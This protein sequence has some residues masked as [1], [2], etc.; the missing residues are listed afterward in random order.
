MTLVT[1]N[2]RKGMQFGLMFF[3][4]SEDALLGNKYRL[5]IESAK[6]A[7]QHSFSSVWLPE[8][9]FTKFGCLY[10]NPSV[11]H[12]ALARETEHIRL[13]AGSVVLPI[14]NPIRIAEEWAVVDNL[15]QGRIGISFASGW[16]PNDFA[17]FPEKYTN[18]HEEMYSGIKMVQKLWQGES[19][20]VKNGKGKQ[21]EVRVYPTP[22]Q[23]QLPVWITAASNPKTFI[24][25][26]EIGANLLTHMF[27]QGIEELAEKIALYRQARAKYG[28]EPEAGQVTVTLHTF[29]GDDID[30]VREQVRVPYC[31][32][33]KSNISLLKGLAQ[34]RD[35]NVDIS[36]LPPEELDDLVNFVF[37]KFSSS[38]ALFGTPETC[39]DLLSQLD[40][41]GVNEV[42][43]L[44]DFGLDADL[45]LK[46]LP[47]LKQLKE[48]YNGQGS[49]ANFLMQVKDD[50]LIAPKLNLS[51]VNTPSR[52]FLSYS[53]IYPQVQQEDLI[54]DIQARC[55]EEIPGYEFYKGLR[56]HGIY[57]DASF[58]GIQCLWRRNGEALGMVQFLEVLE[59]EVDA[60]KIH[61]AFLDACFQ[62][63]FATLPT[64]TVSINGEVLYIPVG[65]RS[66]EICGQLGEQV[67]SHAVLRSQPNETADIFEGDVCIFNQAGKLVLKV[68]GLRLQPTAIVAQ[69]TRQENF[70]DW[71]YELEWKPKISL[72]QEMRHLPPDYMLTPLQLTHRLQPDVE[73]LISQ[74]GFKIYEE[75]LPELNTLS[76][77]Y[78]VRAFQ[79]LGWDF[80]LHKCF[81]VTSLAE[82]L[83]IVD[84]YRR[85]LV[86]L[87]EMLQEEEVL[88]QLD[89]EWEICRVPAVADPQEYCKRLLTLYP[90]CEAELTLL[91]RCGQHL[92]EVLVGKCDPLQLLFPAGSS[93]S[94]EKLYQDSPA[95]QVVNKLVQ[96]AV[97]IAMERLPEER[98]VR[99]LEIGAGTGGTTSYVLSQ[100]PANQTEYLFTDL[101]NLF[102]SKAKQKFSEYPFV[103]YQILDIEQDPQA[104][105]FGLHQ[106]DVILAANVLHATSNLRQTL[107]HIRQILAS[108]GLLVLLEGT[109]RQRW[110]D[111]IFG[112]TEGWWKFADQDLRPSYPLLTHLQWLN[113][114][115]Q[116]GFM[117]VETIP[118][119]QDS[120]GT[121]SQQTLILARN[122]YVEQETEP[123]EAIFHVPDRQGSWLVFA[124]GGGVGQKFAEQLRSC[125]EACT[126]VFPGKS[127]VQLGE[128][129]FSINPAQPEDF[130]RLVNEGIKTGG[131][132]YRGVVHLWSLEAADPEAMTV[133]DLE[134]SFV[135]GC[136]S[137]LHL[138]QALVSDRFS[139]PPSLWLVTQGSQSVGSDPVSPA[140]A[141][142]PLWGLGRV[143]SVEHPQLWGGLVDLDSKASVD[144]S[145]LE[146]SGIVWNQDGEDQVAF[147]QKQCYVARL[148]HKR[149]STEKTLP[150][151]WRF[152]SSY[153]ITGGLG[154]LGL[155]V[156]HWMVEQGARRLILLGRTKL[157]P[158]ANWSAVQEDSPLYNQIKAVRDLESLGATVYLASA[159]VANEAQMNSVLK[160]LQEQGCPS[161][162]GVVH[163][164]GVPQ[165]LRPLQQLEVTTMNAVLRPKVVGSWLL[166]RLLKH[167][168]LDFFV[169]FSSWSS[170]LGV[171]GQNLGSYSAANT[172]LD[173]MAH[174]R[175]A[176]GHTSLSINWGDW[177]E[178]GMRARYI[179]KG[180]RLLPENWTF[181]PKQGINALEHLLW[182]SSVQVGV[183]PVRWSDFFQRFPLMNELPLLRDIALEVPS[184]LKAEERLTQRL[185]FLQTLEEVPLSK[186]RELLLSY[187]QDQAVKVLG[188]DPSHPP[189]PEQSLKELGLDSLMAVEMK[190]KFE[191]ELGVTI[192]IAKFFEASSIAQLVDVLASQL[193]GEDAISMIPSLE[194]SKPTGF[195]IDSPLVEI[196]TTGLKRPFFCVH[197]GAL[198]TRL[199]A[200]LARHLDQEQPFYLLQPP[201]LNNYKLSN[202]EL[203]LDTLLKDI[204]SECI[205][206]LYLCQPQGPYLLGGWSLGGVV[207]FEMT[208]QMQ[209][210]GH[211]V[212][213]LALLDPSPLSIKKV[214]DN[215]DAII[216][217]GFARY[218]GA[219]GGK[220]LSVWYEDLKH[221]DLRQQL[222][223]VLEQAIIAEVVPSDLDLLD[224]KSFF[225][226]YKAG[227]ESAAQQ[228]QNYVPQEIYPVPITLFRANEE[229]DGIVR[230]SDFGWGKFSSEPIE[231]QV[232]PG[233]HYSIFTTPYI[234]EL[235]ERLK[236]C[237]V[238]VNSIAQA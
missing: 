225:Q 109:E 15:S 164:A 8:R 70:S 40:R 107:K 22:I 202:Q 130:H 11:L 200:D 94:V 127:Y 165:P 132:P 137:T 2:H 93:V 167:T 149:K 124:D 24:K 158:R 147:R 228:V 105:G 31:K 238:K 58:Q 71:F 83:G 207:A 153:L 37:Q 10:P 171:V 234:Q 133:D 59:L 90:T 96:D 197:P 206:M 134:A 61:P 159:D 188:L 236:H 222:N 99:I 111:L 166:H 156:A 175:K 112:L 25:A 63:F 120:K 35:R 237:L 82:Q 176:H 131:P 62:V 157:P 116:M 104:Q 16:N 161:I 194:E 21:I 78:V 95:A 195:Q 173:A 235:G 213:M 186:R 152:D 212:A 150:L 66:L 51:K 178:V 89:S 102:I 145:V 162:R 42:A 23:R 181:T 160:T 229:Y 180:N 144:Q 179:Q 30:L 81:C 14:H 224:L 19:I 126:L 136:H 88:R 3:A 227:I 106:F 190:N 187:V 233:D 114:L 67:W 68:S 123:Q 54:Q 85:L 140:I 57:F 108:E 56:K 41:V 230:D 34:S 97:S 101:S 172:F 44:L 12:A 203:K 191:G 182:Q 135:L 72:N 129:L 138:V 226:T 154:D 64:E 231:I 210:Q 75:L 196:Q 100:L 17:F 73:R 36:A 80:C 199:Y 9:H 220:L 192:P 174:Y 91:G 55:Q 198:D 47:H 26:G 115:K 49:A 27:D 139:K 155:Q 65:L 215:K 183:L 33:L 77:N 185:K 121:L 146:L 18:R 52:Q 125:G 92:A 7:D 148:V 98:T 204:A 74:E 103:Q 184:R 217:A 170:L 28:H 209:K 219:R 45:I 232:V 122:S 60:G 128:G 151:T 117:E 43:C 5:L 218:L 87:L 118:Q 205:E 46:N 1:Q 211:K 39:F 168:P 79:Q 143:I 76:I 214:A 53:D 169:L 69:R 20:W 163:A 141:Q 38:R 142:S 48:D 110:L 177:A 84:P 216:I 50:V 221:L 32:Y 201:S 4:S 189:D 113:L 223:Y 29:I 119:A 86:R 193:V 6:F 208:Q 13:L